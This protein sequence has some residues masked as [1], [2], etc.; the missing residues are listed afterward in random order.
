MSVSAHLRAVFTLKGLLFLWGVAGLFLGGVLAYQAIGAWAIL[1]TT[2]RTFFVAAVA[3]V[4]GTSV[5]LVLEG[6][7][8]V[9]ETFV[10]KSLL[11]ADKF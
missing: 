10:P 4:L 3:S 7:P 8:A 6:W 5:Q 1:D 2:S 9:R 11:E